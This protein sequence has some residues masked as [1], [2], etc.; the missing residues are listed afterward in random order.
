MTFAGRRLRTAVRANASRQSRRGCSLLAAASLVF[1]T[2]LAVTTLGAA[3]ASAATSPVASR[4]DNMVTADALPTTQMDGVAWAQVIGGNTV[5]VGGSF[6]NARPAG[7]AAGTQLTPRSNFLAYNLSTGNLITT[8]APSFNAQVKSVALSPDKSILYVGGDFTT[9]SGAARSRIAA[10]NLSTGALISSFAPTVSATVNAIVATAS[11]VYIAGSFGAVNGVSRGRVAALNATT[12]ALTTWN[13]DADAQVNAMVMTPDGSRLIIGGVFANVGGTQNLG[14]AAVDST[15]GAVLPWAANQTI[16][17]YGGN[18]A[19]DTLST[20]GTNV[21]GGGYNFGTDLGNLEGVFSAEANSGNLNWVESCHGDSYGTYPNAKAGVVYVVSHEHQC[22]DLGGFGQTDTPWTTHR[23]TAF[24]IAATGTAQH[25][26]LG[27]HYADYFGTPSPSVVGDWLP[28]YLTGSYTG[29]GQAAWTVTGNDQYV[30]EG[31]EFPVVNG[32]AQQGLTR[33]AIP[34]LATNKQGPRVTTTAFTPN[35]SQASATSARVTWLANWDRDDDQLSYQVLRNGAVVYTTSAHSIS[36]NRPML[37]FT[38]TGLTPG[39]TYTYAV[40]AFDSHN[41]A[42]HGS[43]VS[44]TQPASAPAALSAYGARMKTDGAAPYWPLTEK[45]GTTFFADNAGFGDAIRTGTTAA[46]GSGPVSGTTAT[47]FD[48]STGAGYQ[49]TTSA[50]GPNVF[51]IEAWFKTTSAKGEIVGYG[52]A[53]TGL[54]QNNDRLIYLNASGQVVFGAMPTTASGSAP[55]RVVVTPSAYNNGAWHQVVATLSG[56]G[57]AL[58]VDGALKVSNAG[59]TS[60]QVNYPG[61]WRVG[62]DNL[63]GWSGG[64]GNYFAGSIAQVSIFPSAL[65]ASQVSAHYGLRTS[66]TVTNNPPTAAFTTS[67]TDLS[68]A[69]D[70]TSSSD[71]D[72]TISSYAWTFGDGGTATGASPNHAYAAGGTYPVTLTVTDNGG[73][74]DSTT[75]LI[76]VTAPTGGGTPM[77]YATDTFAR[78]VTGG[79]GSANT[80]GAWAVSGGT[81]GFSVATGVGKQSAKAGAQPAAYLNGLSTLTDTDTTVDVALDNVP[82]GTSGAEYLYV[83]ARHSG[84]NEYQLRLKVATD[85]VVSITLIKLTGGVAKG[86]RTV[87]VPSLTY[88]AGTVL[89]LRFDV[90]GSGSA[91]LQAKVWAGATE[92][93]AWTAVANDASAPFT[94]GAPGLNSYLAASTVA[95]IVASWDNLVVQ[96]IGGG[97]AVI[98][99][100]TAAFTSS[101]SG[102]TASFNASGSA[103]GT[104]TTIQSYSWDFG[105]G[106]AAGAGATPSHPYATDGTYSVKLTVT[107]ADGQTATATHSVTVTAPI[108]APTAAFTSSSSGLTA[109]FDASASIAGTGSTIQSYAWDFGDSTAAGS[110]VS[111]SH[112]YATDGTYTVVLTVTDADGQSAVAT[113][114]VTVAAGTP[115]NP[116]P[117]AAF[118]SSSSGLT[119]SFDASSSAAGTG[120]TISGYSWTFGDGSTGSGVNPS[121]PYTTDGTYPVVLTVTDADNQTASV[122]HDVTVSSGAVTPLA[123]DA[124][125]RAVASGWGTADTGG[126]W[127]TSGV[128]F[129]V[130]GNAGVMSQKAGAQ[131]VASLSTLSLTDTDATVDVALDK[132][133]SGTSGSDYLYVGARRVGTSEYQ[134]RVRVLADASMQASLIK[135]T[136]GAARGLQTVTIAGLTYTAGTVLHLRFDVSGSSTV[137]LRGKAWTGSTEPTVWSA[138]ATDAASPFT[139]GAPSLSAYLA[140]AGNAPI[141]ASWDNYSVV[142]L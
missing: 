110:G 118:T 135:Q 55:K 109:S 28:D 120:T 20:D 1:A 5:Y 123:A 60:G 17:D 85:G 14:L 119:A 75:Q 104:G 113:H 81:T 64:S 48:G 18:A 7:A 54:S 62:G 8:F 6:A 59:T 12:G 53:P 2:A 121:H 3:A 98:P 76:T 108:P 38:D 134:L 92:P 133:P 30:V 15:T 32:A 105:D 37:G 40:N 103:P 65:S 125:A 84:T 138:T 27:G 42:A 91:L 23:T 82:T 35:V 51:S 44:Y 80:G 93:S 73:A 122:S 49:E 131:P 41:N 107:D 86:L 132:V 78:N 57:M 16:H 88:A 129:S 127:A 79:W 56:S 96:T 128:T 89:H 34:S 9:A 43:T 139:S 72:G 130:A 21:Y 137:T 141:A 63:A 66:G 29:Q 11:T 50:F 70:G 136:S 101:T 106:S 95:P 74:T 94:S 102:L 25:N 99:P 71:S 87:T 19:I 22:S 124:F 77:T 67:A 31:G 114:S 33:F 36:W 45:S 83:V 4:T 69:F 24:T 126:A 61:Y 111:P 39:Q 68:V 13:P 116:P 90:S 142:A 117:T 10:Y 100:P 46:D 112:P 115:V 52:T 26:Y 47:S 97:A 140:A 58:Y